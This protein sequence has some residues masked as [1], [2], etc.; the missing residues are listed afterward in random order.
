VF[1]SLDVVDVPTADVDV[2][3]RADVADIGLRG[4]GV[5]LTLILVAVLL[6][7]SCSSHLGGHGAGSVTT[8]LPLSSTVPRSSVAGRTLWSPA[9][10]GA[11]QWQLSGGIDERVDVPTFDVDLFETPTATVDRLHASGDG[12]ICY[13]S[14]GTLEPQRPDS[15]TVPA[16]VVGK[17]L[18]DYP[19]ER[20]LDI[21][22]L[23]ALAPWIAAR[24][25]LCRSKGFDA[26][27]PDNVDGFTNDSGFPL[28]AADQLKFNRVVAQTAHE[29][30][31]SV[32]LK[33][34]LDQIPVLV[35]AFDWALNEQC[36]E[37]SEC[38]AYRPFVA[39]KKAV[40]HVEYQGDLAS[41][42]STAGA[43]GG[44]SSMR[45]HRSLDAYREPCP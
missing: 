15:G 29:R 26:V 3:G 24:M 1:G 8:G 20:W 45:K 5:A 11:W 35:G 42:C 32:G 36:V 33:N 10:G 14:V 9:P 34:D 13:I 37:F 38:Q 16:S 28:S 4:R 39:A 2:A 27:E 6:G 12:V 41:I 43:I 40:L 22:R 19:D 17:P 30:G 31:L 21:R 25:D 44:M 7:A 18:A 23:D